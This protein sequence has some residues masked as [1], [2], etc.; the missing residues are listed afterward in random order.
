MIGIN[1]QHLLAGTMQD[2]SIVIQCAWRS[3]IARIGLE[4]KKKQKHLF[5]RLVRRL[6]H[7]EDAFAK[8]IK[9]FGDVT[10]F[11]NMYLPDTAFEDANHVDTLRRRIMHVFENIECHQ[12]NSNIDELRNSIQHFENL[13]GQLETKIHNIIRENISDMNIQAIPKIIKS[14]EKLSETNNN[15]QSIFRAEMLLLNAQIRQNMHRMNRGFDEAREYHEKADKFHNDSQ[16]Y[17]EQSETHH[18]QTH[19][20][21]DSVQRVIG[22]TTMVRIGYEVFKFGLCVA[23][24]VLES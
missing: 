6:P 7:A 8:H 15:L 10:R 19:E 17:Y 9:L 22:L 12:S 16:S 5:G 18:K 21:I 24:A 4:N 13:T 1:V 2:E 20:K 11:L 23:E 3:H 14:L